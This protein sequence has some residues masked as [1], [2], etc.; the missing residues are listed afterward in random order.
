MRYLI[1]ITLF[2]SAASAQDAMRA[3]GDYNSR[4]AAAA[5]NLKKEMSARVNAYAAASRANFLRIRAQQ[6]AKY[7]TEPPLK[8]YKRTD[9]PKVGEFEAMVE[10]VSEAS[11]QAYER[12]ENERLDAHAQSERQRNQGYFDELE[13][14]NRREAEY[15][16]ELA[17]V[18]RKVWIDDDGV[19][20]A[21]PDCP[22]CLHKKQ[23]LLSQVQTDTLIDV[24]DCP[25][26]RPDIEFIDFT[27]LPKRMKMPVA[28]P[29]RPYTPAEYVATWADEIDTR[30]FSFG[31]AYYAG[32]IPAPG[33]KYDIY[34]VTVK[35]NKFGLSWGSWN[36][37]KVQ[38]QDVVVEIM[39]ERRASKNTQ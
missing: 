22:F 13:Q 3:V 14:Y 11:L 28:P 33:R 34:M 26:S 18:D 16:T 29:E 23:R 17:K 39:G 9:R 6:R 38:D 25:I 1:I 21:D 8:D 31:E 32:R 2:C 4:N 27:K 12:A 15:T 37:M 30:T 20:F 5:N 36:K 24:R 35:D 19:M 7:A 10:K